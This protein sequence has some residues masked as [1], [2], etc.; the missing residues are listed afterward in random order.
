[1]K[2]PGKISLLC[3]GVLGLL[4]VVGI[5]LTIGWRPFIGPK[6][7]ALT[8][9]HFEST[10]ERVARGKY[11]VQSVAGCESCH[12]PRD[13]TQHGAP[14]LPGMELAGQVLAVP[15]FPGLAVAPNL[16]PDPETGAAHWSDDQ[17]ARAIREGVKHD[18]STL[19]PMMPYDA[20]RSLSDE[21]LASIVVYLRSV[22]PVHNP[23]PSMKVNFPVSY[24]VRSA[25][26]PVTAPV[27]GPNP[28][29]VIARGKYLA[30]MGCGCHRAVD[31]LD[32]AGGE[33]LDGPWGHVISANITPDASGIG[34]FSEATFITALR[35]GYVGARKL[36]SVMP[37]GEFKNQ[38][39]D[40]LKAIF[41]YLRTVPAVKH[42]VDNSL[43]AT[44]CK[45]C[46]EKHGAG[47]QN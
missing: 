25:P 9:R 3:L 2:K 32:Y 17:I 6:K 10:P 16:T 43:P 46:K 39:D 37:F 29:D 13:W 36:N 21:D 47:D 41:A 33:K 26:E 42:R 44:Y 8:D 27:P 23:L 7:R 31:N 14:M 30:T 1:M 18:G 24:L 34:Y 5:S 4:L 38:T 19:F 22:T 35:T 45:V 12:A 11:L 28:L 40:D 15:G 20:Y